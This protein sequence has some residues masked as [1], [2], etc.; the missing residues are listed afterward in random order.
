MTML[1]LD[2]RQR[3]AL[4][5]TLREL[6]NFVAAALV[7]GQIVGDRPRSWLILAGIAAWS[8]LVAWALFLERGRQWKAR[9]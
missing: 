2:R 1:R 3:E 8:V 5:Y 4:G 9:S 6:A 7:L